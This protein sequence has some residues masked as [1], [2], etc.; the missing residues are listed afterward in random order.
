MR[1][2]VEVELAALGDGTYSAKINVFDLVRAISGQNQDRVLS[3][4]LVNS[5]MEITFV[6]R[7][8]SVMDRGEG[9]RMRH[10]GRCDLCGIRAVHE[11]ELPD[12]HCQTCLGER[13]PSR[14]S[15]VSVT[16]GD[17]IMYM[18]K[19]EQGRFTEWTVPLTDAEVCD[20]LSRK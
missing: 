18:W 1:I 3:Y 4:W 6:P 5:N 2:S 12:A 16:P 8:S 14:L 9:N 11:D 10:I 19:Q 15:V 17:S 7:N 13:L 20:W